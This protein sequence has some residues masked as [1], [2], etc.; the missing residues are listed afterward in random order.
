M[1]NKNQVLI[2][3]EQ[4]NEALKTVLTRFEPVKD[5]NFFTDSPAGKEK[6]DGICMQL[7]AIGESLKKID[8]LTDKKLLQ[9]YSEIDWTGAKGVRDVISHHYFDIDAEEIFWIC[10][11]QIGPMQRTV[12]KIITDINATDIE[13]R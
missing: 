13:H 1:S 12:E 8:K 3:L 9:E 6:L 5:S 7:I 10:D 2:I 11:Q 4:I